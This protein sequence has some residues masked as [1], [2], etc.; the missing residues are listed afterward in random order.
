[1]TRKGKWIEDVSTGA[2]LADV[3][4]AAIAARLEMVWHYL[5]LAASRPTSET[6]NV[7]QLRV[8]VRRA[9]AALE[10]FA[11]LLPPRRALWLSKRLR[12]IRKAAGPARDLDVLAERMRVRG[13]HHPG[14]AWD[15]LLRQAARQRRRAQKPIEK[16]HKRLV[17]KGFMRRARKFIERIGP[18]TKLDRLIEP[19][20][21]VAGRRVFRRM[22]DDFFSLSE[23]Q[24]SG[25]EVLHAFRIQGKQLRYAM[26]IFAAAFEP[27][28]RN[29]LYPQ[30]E[31]LQARLGEVNDHVAAQ[32][33]LRDWLAKATDEPTAE[34]LRR[35][36][37]EEHESLVTSRREFISWWTRD[38]RQ[39]LQ[40]QF[41]RLT[42]EGGETMPSDS[43]HS[44][45]ERH[46][47]AAIPSP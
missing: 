22:A 1:M 11:S 17:R 32:F 19:R 18:R 29:E 35:W 38:R 44:E 47:V 46:E 43:E 37:H 42:S 27:S 16:M 8:A 28:F 3:T 2:S 7:H 9:M 10:I 39:E 13:E 5:S 20:Y 21:V 6:E 41:F 40:R 36:I 24:L 33:Q 34:A 15:E 26:E 4:S 31:A 30:I 12:H 14:P 25:D 23:T 45:I